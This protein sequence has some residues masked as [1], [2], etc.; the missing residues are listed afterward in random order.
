MRNTGQQASEKSCLGTLSVMLQGRRHSTLI[1]LVKALWLSRLSS[2]ML[3][4]FPKSS[5]VAVR[6][7]PQRSR[8]GPHLPHLAHLAGTWPMWT[9]LPPDG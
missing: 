2:G 9:A 8:S 4:A 5:A 6:S 3:S 1:W 7:Q